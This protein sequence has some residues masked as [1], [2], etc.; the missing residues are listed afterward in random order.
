MIRLW[1]G[2][3]VMR[4]HSPA[5]L[6]TTGALTLL[7]VLTGCGSTDDRPGKAVEVA[8][9][10]NYGSFGTSTDIDCGNGKSLNVGGSNNRLTVRGRCDAVNVGGADNTIKLARVDGELSV[11]GLHNTITYADGTP[12]VHDTGSGNHIAKG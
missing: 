10:I 12:T 8:N 6:L 5:R 1:L 4:T 7:P 9:T 2:S 11:V 3:W